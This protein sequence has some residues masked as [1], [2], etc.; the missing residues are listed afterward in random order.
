MLRSH[1]RVALRNHSYSSLWSVAPL[2]QVPFHCIRNILLHLAHFHTLWVNREPNVRGWAVLVPPISPP[3][4]T[5]TAWALG[6]T[7]GHF[8]ENVEM[9]SH[10]VVGPRPGWLVLERRRWREKG[11]MEDISGSSFP[12]L[13]YSDNPINIPQNTVLKNN[14]LNWP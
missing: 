12:H 5:H 10:P 6:A 11:S 14:S 2:Y 4:S 13:C 9:F 7:A 8:R 3:P 1:H